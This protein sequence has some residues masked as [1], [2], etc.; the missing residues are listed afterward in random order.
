MKKNSVNYP[1]THSMEK[2]KMMANVRNR[3]EKEF[4]RRD[5]NEKISEK[6]GNSQLE[7]E[8]F[9]KNKENQ[10]MEN[11]KLICPIVLVVG[12]PIRLNSPMVFFSNFVNFLILTK[13]IR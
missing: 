3:A 2:R 4:F 10:K 9:S 8:L 7:V 6:H 13:N 5:D 1:L 12:K 11:Q